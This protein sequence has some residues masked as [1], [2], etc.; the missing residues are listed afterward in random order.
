[1][2]KGVNRH[3]HDPDTGPYVTEAPMRQDL[4]LIK[5]LN[6]NTVPTSH[7]PLF[8]SSSKAVSQPSQDRK[9]PFGVEPNNIDKHLFQVLTFRSSCPTPLN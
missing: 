7:L 1:M 5:Q 6:L 9:S 3:D 4:E 8:P 2:V